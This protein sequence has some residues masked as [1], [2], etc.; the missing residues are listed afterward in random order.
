MDPKLYDLLNNLIRAYNKDENIDFEIS[1]IENAL[2]KV[3]QET[4]VTSSQVALKMFE[5]IKHRKTPVTTDS[6]GA[7]FGLARSTVA[8]RFKEL[9]NAGY[10]TQTRKGHVTYYSVSSVPVALPESVDISL[11]PAAPKTIWPVST[12]KTSY[13]HIRGYDD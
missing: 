3:R 11:Q 12:F 5:Y 2:H 7:Y 8:K 1:Q 6:V 9:V 10:L 4:P 13:P